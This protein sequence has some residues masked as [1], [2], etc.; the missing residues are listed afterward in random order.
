MSECTVQFGA[1]TRVSS[2]VT[3]FLIP[4]PHSDRPNDGAIS[5]SVDLSPMSAM[6]F[7]YVQ[8]SS[9]L[10]S[11]GQSQGGMGQA[12][13]EGQKL[14]SNRILRIMERTLLNGGAIDSEAL[15]VQS[16]KWVWRLQVDVTVLDHGGNL[17]DACVLSAV[18]ALRHFRKPEV[19]ITEA[20]GP[21]VLHSDER[22]PTPL[23]LH[24]TPLT[25]TFALFADPTGA[26]T[27][28][29]ALVDPSYR[30]E[31]VTDGTTTFSFNKY[32]EMCSLDYPGGCE[33]K[34]RQLITCAKL[35]KRKCV[36]LCE[37]LETSLLESDQKAVQERLDRLKL[38][39]GFANGNGTKLPDV[40]EDSPFVERTD[41][42][43]DGDAM[44]VDQDGLKNKKAEAI[45]AAEE[46]SYRI[47]ALDYAQGHVAAKVKED[48][49]SST[50]SSGDRSKS[51][52]PIFG[53]SLMAAMLKSAGDNAVVDESNHTDQ[54]E[55]G[56]KSKKESSS[57]RTKEADD[58]FATLV[59]ESSK[60]AGSRPTAEGTKS[61]E[62]ILSS[63]MAL[64]SDE[65][66]E[67]ATLRSEF[68][69]TQVK[70]SEEPSK[71]KKIVRKIEK[72]DG[73]DVDDLAMAVKSKKKKK[74]KK[75]KK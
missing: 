55:L 34:P 23:P 28:V 54:L 24:H 1:H 51:K 2:V 16:G 53:G 7:E 74:S 9:T 58:E 65:E 36:E 31:L 8:P 14:L 21:T 66:E 35:G 33:L 12:Q 32:G 38:A 73:E 26:S 48:K 49:P 40:S 45:A 56:R 22:E 70:E 37:I 60:V 43:R 69:Y 72:D 62:T 75:S 61:H 25:V 29:S 13:D 46:E 67:T 5:F 15:C 10:A 17:V 30:E 57:R 71:T 52:G 39:N 4:P 47:L 41:L 3:C 19:D 18:A 59:E 20:G 68:T 27:T 11:G 42:E 50:G 44:E 6:G 64:D 63:A